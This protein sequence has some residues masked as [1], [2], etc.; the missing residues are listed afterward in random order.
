M[1]ACCTTDIDMDTLFTRY[2]FVRKIV[3]LLMAGIL[4]LIT[5][6]LGSRIVSDK[7]CPACPGFG[8]CAGNTDCEKY[9]NKVKKPGT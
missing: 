9:G 3:R 7:N 4:A 2:E 8:I 5:A 1:A 6:A